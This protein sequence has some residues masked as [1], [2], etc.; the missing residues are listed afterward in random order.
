M[1]PAM[2]VPGSMP[3]LFRQIAQYTTRRSSSPLFCISGTQAQKGAP[4]PKML[5]LPAVRVAPDAAGKPV[6]EQG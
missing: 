3:G 2:E 1:V 5:L 6:D 4:L